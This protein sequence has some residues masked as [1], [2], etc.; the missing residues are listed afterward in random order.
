LTNAAASD[1]DDS[2]GHVA[3]SAAVFKIVS[4][5]HFTHW[6]IDEKLP[7]ATHLRTLIMRSDNR[8][9]PPA[10]NS[11]AYPRAL[12]IRRFILTLCRKFLQLIDV[13]KLVMH[14][15]DSRDAEPQRLLEGKHVALVGVDV[16]IDEAGQ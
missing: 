9:R 15:H 6:T 5:G 11:A 3:I 4:L 14:I 16:G 7:S 2:L 1:G 13:R 10:I 8:H 12:E